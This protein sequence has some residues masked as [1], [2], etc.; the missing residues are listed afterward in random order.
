MEDNVKDVQSA[1]DNVP[2]KRQPKLHMN[3][4]VKMNKV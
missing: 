4:N 3:V 2:K 1:V